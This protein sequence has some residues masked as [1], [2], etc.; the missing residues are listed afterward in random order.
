MKSRVKNLNDTTLNDKL[1]INSIV[2]LDFFLILG[3][4]I[5]QSS[6]FYSVYAATSLMLSMALLFTLLISNPI[7]KSTHKWRQLVAVLALKL[8]LLLQIPKA[9]V[10]A[11]NLWSFFL[12]TMLLIESASLY[13]FWKSFEVQLEPL[14]SYLKTKSA[15]IAEITSQKVNAWLRIFKHKEALIHDP[16]ARNKRKMKK[17]TLQQWS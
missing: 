7:Y 15:R 14:L 5:G 6:F 8:I 9:L 3:M 10:S 11:L 2:F 16:I 4:V 1:T 12:I 13:L 17:A